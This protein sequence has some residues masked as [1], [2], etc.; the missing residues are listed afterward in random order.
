MATLVSD[1]ARTLREPLR[2][3]REGRGMP[4]EPSK[5]TRHIAAVPPTHE[6]SESIIATTRPRPPPPPE[7]ARSTAKLAGLDDRGASRAVPLWPA[8]LA[9]RVP[10]LIVQA[11]AAPH[12]EACA[13][14]FR[15]RHRTHPPTNSTDCKAEERLVLR[16]SGS[17]YQGYL[18]YVNTAA[19]QYQL[20]ARPAAASRR[21]R[22]EV[23]KGLVR[24]DVSG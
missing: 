2:R 3:Q 24:G 9:P 13:P 22:G 23:G 10:S 17:T 16:G 5:R 4:S 20:Q 18:L 12:R 21:R 15:L 1:Y 14:T 7:V 19:R 8:R 11:P 6:R